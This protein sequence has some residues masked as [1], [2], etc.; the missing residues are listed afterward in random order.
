MR[1]AEGKGQ[2]SRIVL[3]AALLAVTTCVSAETIDRVLAVVAGQLITLSDLN[4][5]RDLGIVTPA[6]NVSDPVADVLAK[7]IDRELM[8]AEV[9]RYAQRV[10]CGERALAPTG[11]VGYQLQ[12]GLHARGL[13]VHR[14]G[15]FVGGGGL[16]LVEES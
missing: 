11:F 3:L 9:E 1:R 6:P 10:P 5:L 13:E 15:A 12:D 14:E 16:G 7:L 4:A 8:L 2:R